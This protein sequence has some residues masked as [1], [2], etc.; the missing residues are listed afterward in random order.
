MTPGG[1]VT[2]D[3]EKKMTGVV[4][5]TVGAKEASP[6][7]TLYDFALVKKAHLAFQAKGWQPAS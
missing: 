2:S 4:L 6:A 5:K 7:D 3:T 1:T